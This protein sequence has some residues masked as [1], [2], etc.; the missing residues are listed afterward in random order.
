MKQCTKC[1]VQKPLTQYSK[2]KAGLQSI[3]KDC[4][5]AYAKNYYA[6]NPQKFKTYIEN[7][8]VWVQNN[9]TK[10]K[11]KGKEKYAKSAEKQKA[12][13]KQRYAEDPKRAKSNNLKKYGITLA[14]F[15]ELKLKQNGKCAICKTELNHALKTHVD[16]CHKTNVVRG[17]LCNLCNPGLGMFKD[18]IKILKSAQ[19]YLEKYK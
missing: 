18:S 8:Q 16:H 2:K 7:R 6:Q 15:E 10:A 19:A 1:G 14:Q 3:C 17:I 13:H 4:A 11:E 5:K 9:P 12:N